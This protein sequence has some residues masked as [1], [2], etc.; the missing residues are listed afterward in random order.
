M[1]SDDSA[2]AGVHVR[3]GTT[4]DAEFAA[5]LHTS[6]IGEGFLAELGPRFLT[7]LYRRIVLDDPS[8]LLVAQGPDGPLGFIAGTSAVGGLYR[9]FL[10]HDGARAVVSVPLRVLLGSWRRVLETTGYG[11]RRAP[12]ASESGTADAGESPELLSVAVAANQQGRGVGG[13][14]V[15]AF[16]EEVRARGAQ[17][18]TVV[19]GADNDAAIAMYRRAG[20]GNDDRL[21]VHRGTPSLRLTWVAPSAATAP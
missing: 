13:T 3:R 9:R 14:L 10:R 16:L 2:A 7:L 8:F 5:A 20:F 17:R 6:A 4:Q 21:E 18:A 19:V 15:R 1:G 12:D 11:M